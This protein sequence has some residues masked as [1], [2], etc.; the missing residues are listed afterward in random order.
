MEVKNIETNSNPSFFEK[1]KTKVKETKD[2]LVERKENL[3]KFLGEHPELVM[4]LISGLTMLIG[5]GLKIAS[6]SANKRLEKCKVK[7]DVTGEYYIT[8]H[9]LTNEEILELSDRMVDGETKGN[10][11]KEMDLLR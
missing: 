3:M 11:L 7:D 10:A 6:N 4:P 5:G 9:P 8:D 1:I 2:N